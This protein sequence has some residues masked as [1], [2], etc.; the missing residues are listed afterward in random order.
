MDT[1]WFPITKYLIIMKLSIV[2]LAITVLQVSAAAFSQEKKVSIDV[3][4]QPIRLVLN[5]ITTKTNY[6]FVYSSN[7]FPAETRV[8]IHVRETPVSEIMNSLLKPTGFSFVFL[9]EDEMIVISPKKKKDDYITIRGKVTD[10]KGKPIPGTTIYIKG[11]GIAAIAGSNGDYE[12]IADPNSTI[13]FYFVGYK[14]LE[15]PIKG[16]E[17]IDVVLEED[18]SKMDEVVII[19]YGTTT[20]RLN[21][22][23]VGRITAEEIG[24]QP[25]GNILQALI[26]R[27][28]GVEIS[29][30]SGYAS[31]NFNVAIRGEKNL[32]NQGSAAPPLYIVDGVPIAISTGD[33]SNAGLNQ[34]GFTGSN[35]GQS[36]LYSLNPADIESIE[37]LKDADATAIYGSRAANGVILITT[38]RGKTGAASLDLNFYTGLTT[39]PGKMDLLNTQQYLEMRREAFKNDGRIPDEFSA[40]DLTKW[41][42]NRYTDWQKEMGS[43]SRT[44]DLQL[45]YSGGNEFTAFRFSGGYHK[46]TPPVPKVFSGDF[47]D[48]RISS[49]LS[50]D[51]SSKDRKLKT[52]FVVSYANTNGNLPGGSVYEFTLAP[53]APAILNAEGK[54]NYQ[55]YG[56][57]LPYTIA[58]F[59]QPYKTNVN[60]FSSNIAISYQFLKNLNLNANFGYSET[61]MDQ[62]LTIPKY[63]QGLNPADYTGITRIGKN[64]T[65]GWITE[66]KLNYSET[67]GKGSLQFL[68]GAT[69]QSNITEGEDTDARGFVN[70]NLLEDPRYAQTINSM[71]KF[72]EY[73]FQGY[74]ARLNY[75]YDS[76]YILN[77][78]GRRD[79]SSRFRGGDQMGNFWSLGGA[80]I[81]S[82]ES[83]LKN[84]MSFLSF[85]KLRGSI[86]TTGSAAAGDYQY[87]KLWESSQ[88]GRGYDGSPVINLYQPENP[89]FKWQVNKKI[90]AALELGFLDNRISLSAGI[91]KERNRD[92]LVNNMLPAFTGFYSVVANIPAVLENNGL[93]FTLN[94]VNIKRERF[95]W[96]TSFN[97]SLNRNKLKAFPGL[98][99]SSYADQYVIGKPASVRLLLHYT[100]INKETGEYT[101]EDRN[102]T[103]RTEGYGANSDRNPV[104]LTPS[105]G[106]AMQN[107]I[108][109][110]NW[111]LQ[112]STDF[113]K[114]RAIYSPFNQV[115]GDL[116]NQPAGVFSR[117][118]QPGD[119]S[120][121]HKFTTGGSDIF[122]FRNSDGIV[123]DASYLR[124]Q[125]LSLSYD[126]PVKMTSSVKAKAL[127]IYAQGQNLLTISNYKGQDPVNPGET[128]GFIPQR[129]F[130]SGLQLTF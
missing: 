71:Y 111:S 97:L 29:Q 102:G 126:L 33:L 94:S 110:G 58:G 95:N 5:E 20:Q 16:R 31:G 128:F 73:K 107:V 122:D 89:G 76:K 60:N 19:G 124:L 52:N 53:N 104:D 127:R 108:S 41:D 117:W 79:G 106:G 81:F 82:E 63:S 36:P 22:G 35:S 75:N 12:I 37:V 91:Y 116:Y 6:K 43:S 121:G 40:P 26:S 120:Q 38:K 46:D 129:V 96:S 80:W 47:K 66:P 125:S 9:K 3:T 74:F 114:Q 11:T 10:D 32:L 25:V 100:G 123:S 103:G 93:E 13:S 24:K 7:L 17:K 57:T 15:M 88:G 85:G 55:E 28:P 4:D 119:M 67:I 98:E 2:V 62:I 23:S 68:L 50:L 113:K 49:M 64:N 78:S 130:T 21:T 112:I 118:Q 101:F 115:P 54:P 59:F 86:G 99:T 61:R 1:C 51:H 65:R 77:L 72:Q 69:L 56:L 44:Y 87:L 70:D 27:I 45:S 109:L 18:I 92:I 105:F 84:T 83:F 30:K 42:Q 90:E 14:R 48:Q 39:S 8:D 34:N